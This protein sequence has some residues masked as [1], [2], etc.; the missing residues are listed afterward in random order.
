VASIPA[1]NLTLYPPTL[2]PTL[3][4]EQN[5]AK[6][7]HENTTNNQKKQLEKALESNKKKMGD[8]ESKSIVAR[9]E[10]LGGSFPTPTRNYLVLSGAYEV[11]DNEEEARENVPI[12]PADGLPCTYEADVPLVRLIFRHNPAPGMPGAVGKD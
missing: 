4:F 6:S 7:T 5:I 10:E 12:D 11:P 8:V 3:Q 9:F 1:G 2:T